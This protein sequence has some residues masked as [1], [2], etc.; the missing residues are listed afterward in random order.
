[1][2]S[3]SSQSKVDFLLFVV[4]IVVVDVVVVVVVVNVFVN[5]VVAVFVL[6]FCCCYQSITISSTSS[7]SK[8]DF[9]FLIVISF[10]NFRFLA[11]K[12]AGSL[13]RVE[14]AFPVSSSGH[15]DVTSGS[16]LL[17]ISDKYLI[18]EFLS[19][20]FFEFLSICSFFI[21]ISFLASAKR[22]A[23]FSSMLEIS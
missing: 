16:C 7:H 21:L 18:C 8:V 3:T 17:S 10:T 6:C 5:V 11:V 2:S 22:R 20:S 19:I 1:M 12:P 15:D 23:M 14:L 13:E 9:L 4:K